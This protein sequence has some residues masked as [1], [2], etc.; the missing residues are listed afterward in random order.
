MR[1][2]LHTHSMRLESGQ[3]ILVA[4]VVADSGRIG[5]G[6]SFRLD[7][8][9]ARRMAECEAGIRQLEPGFTRISW[10]TEER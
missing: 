8:T 7:A 2:F 3:E 4:R 6:F 9:E 1:A 10:I 5:Y